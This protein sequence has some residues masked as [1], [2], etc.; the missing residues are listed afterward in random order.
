MVMP[1]RLWVLLLA[2]VGLILGTTS[3]SLGGNGTSRPHPIGHTE[4]FGNEKV[5]DFMYPQQFFCTDESTDDLDGPGHNGDGQVSAVDPDEFQF[6]S[7]GPPGS[8]C[9]VGRTARGSLPTIDPTGRPVANAEPVWAILPFFDGDGDGVIDAVDPTPGVDVQCP[10]PG[11]PITVHRGAFG[12]CTEHPSTLHAEPIG[13]GDIPLPNHS[14]VIDGDT[15]NPIWWQTIAVRV[16]D[17]SIWPDVN[18]RCPA[19]PEGGEPCLTSL[20]ALRDAQ[21]AGRAAPDTPSNVWLFFDSNQVPG[22]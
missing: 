3:P 11:P 9:I 6:P 1:R 16:F 10:E 15:F 14:H 13:F 18:G 21:A 5:L 7:M 4:G 2:G 8:P 19:N 17:R 22:L 12:T 20:D